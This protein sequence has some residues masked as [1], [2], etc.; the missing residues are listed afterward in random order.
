MQNY[1]TWIKCQI[2]KYKQ[3]LFYISAS[4]QQEV[5]SKQSMVTKFS[6]QFVKIN[7]GMWPHWETCLFTVMFLIV[8]TLWTFMFQN[9]KECF[10]KSI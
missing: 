6:Q 3:S 9:M 10:G 4:V 5:I 8:E 1:L 2:L 7:N